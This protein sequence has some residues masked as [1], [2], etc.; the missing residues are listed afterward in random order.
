MIA[1]SGNDTLI[2]GS[3]A[4]STTMTGGS[5]NDAFVFFR[6]AVGGA[7]DVI[8]NFAAN[9]SVY[10]EGYAATGSAAAM[11]S[12]AVVSSAGLSLTLS[13]GTTITFS[14]LTNQSALDGKLQYG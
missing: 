8:T 11:Q 12:A 2:A 4:G 3:A 1:G 9:D 10:I 14:N 6:Q 7:N 5:G 13:D